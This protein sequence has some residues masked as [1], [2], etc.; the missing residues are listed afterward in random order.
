MWRTLYSQV[1]EV[2]EIFKG[3][4][5]DV[6]QTFCITYFSERKMH[7]LKME[8]LSTRVRCGHFETS[9]RGDVHASVEARWKAGGDS[10]DQKSPISV[11]LAP[12]SSL[13]ACRALK[14]ALSPF[15]TRLAQQ[16]DEARSAKEWSWRRSSS[17][18]V[19]RL[20]LHELWIKMY[21]S[22]LMDYKMTVVDFSKSNKHVFGCNSL[23]SRWGKF[24]SF[25]FTLMV[26]FI[27]SGIGGG[28]LCSVLERV[29]S[30]IQPFP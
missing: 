23:N 13:R 21:S 8:N 2:G 14:H 16:T 17:P 20:Q 15:S 19:Q 6:G 4:F 12:S 7:L 28:F 29:C 22:F 24:F 26:G 5:V 10:Q 18:A 3:F 1:F 25:D 30:W 9:E 11:L 27:S